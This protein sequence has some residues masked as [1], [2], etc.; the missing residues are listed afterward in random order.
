MNKKKS[1]TYIHR[2]SFES[3]VPDQLPPRQL[4]MQ[5]LYPVMEEALRAIAE[6][7]GA[8]QMVPNRFSVYICA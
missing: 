6:L 8:A 7:N 5:R 1:G 3:F 4:D 2:K